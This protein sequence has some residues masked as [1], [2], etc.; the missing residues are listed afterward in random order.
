MNTQT[1]KTA[2]TSSVGKLRA[3][4]ANAAQVRALTTHPDVV[5]LRAERT[6]TAVD[7]LFWVAMVLALAF[8]MVNVQ[9]FAAEDAAPGSLPWISAWLLDPMVSLVLIAVLLAEQVTARWQVK[10]GPWVR[11]TK[12]FAFAA[13]YVMNTWQPWSHLDPAGIVLHSVPPVIVLLIAEAAPHVRERITEAVLMAAASARGD[14]DAG[15]LVASVTE[16]QEAA[17]LPSS[18][19]VNQEPARPR[20][21]ATR[22]TS[23]KPAKKKTGRLFLADYVA[24]AREHH[25]PGH[26]VTPA[27][28]REHIPGIGRATSKNVADTLNTETVENTTTA[29]LAAH[30]PTV[31]AAAESEAA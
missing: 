26:L 1:T 10:T 11:R 3:A 5:A 9:Q 12:V 20:R 24:M 18:P 13:T 21:T 23:R 22:S 25:T 14:G 27:W 31:P 7:T 15:A 6:R 16:G 17:V 2:D 30:N 19:Q 28:V 29:A 4:A 8:T